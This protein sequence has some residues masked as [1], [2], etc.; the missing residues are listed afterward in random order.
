M[1]HSS[2]K[3]RQMISKRL[4]LYCQMTIEH[5]I[6]YALYIKTILLALIKLQLHGSVWLLS[7][8]LLSKLGQMLPQNCPFIPKHLFCPINKNQIV[9][10]N[11]SQ[12]WQ[13][14]VK[15]SILKH[16]GSCVGGQHDHRCSEPMYRICVLMQW[17]KDIMQIC[18]SIFACDISSCLCN[19]DTE[20]VLIFTFFLPFLPHCVVLGS[21]YVCVGTYVLFCADTTFGLV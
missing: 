16:T 12:L 17:R 7:I 4:M 1:H 20:T 9:Y 6:C 21:V 10:N 19:I 2:C 15:P 5:F 11:A 13:Q 14:P 8:T 3:R 18:I